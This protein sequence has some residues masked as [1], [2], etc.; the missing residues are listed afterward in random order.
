MAQHA[1]A[2]EAAEAAVGA[3][4]ES[5]GG[6]SQRQKLSAE[7]AEAAPSNFDLFLAAAMADGAIQPDPTV[8]AVVATE[9]VEAA[10]SGVGVPAKSPPNRRRSLQP[11]PPPRRR[12]R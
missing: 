4:G 2:A 9:A 10:A 1:V 8:A 5:G 3:G 12:C 11:R 7:A 6:G